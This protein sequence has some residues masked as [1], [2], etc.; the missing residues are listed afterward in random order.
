LE[1]HRSIRFKK[2]ELQGFKS[3]PDKT[4]LLFN[5]DICAIVGP[6]GCGKSNI[7]DALRWVLGEQGPS[8]LRARA[9][10]DVIFNGTAGRKPVG[11][12][13]IT[14]TIECPA[15]SLPLA[16]EEIEISRR[17][18]RSGE[19]EYLINRSP[20]RLKDIVDLFL[21]T[22]MGKG[23][24]SLIE[25]G[26]VDALVTAK[27]ED[28][29]VFLEQMAGIE[30]YKARKKEALSKLTITENN[31]ARVQDVVA[32]VKS[33][34]ISLARQARKASK[35]RSI[36]Q[37]LDELIC[38]S[39]AGRYLRLKN[40]LKSFK[41][42]MTSLQNQMARNSAQHGVQSATLLESRKQV[43]S[44][45]QKL[46]QASEK[47]D[48]AE[49]SINYLKKRIADLKNR[50]SDLQNEH[51]QAIR[52]ISDIENQD[53]DLKTQLEELMKKRTD[54]HDLL[55]ELKIQ[56]TKLE[57]AHQKLTEADKKRS[58]DLAEL[59]NIR[60]TQIEKLSRIQNRLTTITEGTRRVKKQ[61]VIMTSEYEKFKNL[62]TASKVKCSDAATQVKAL[63]KK[64]NQT[65]LKLQKISR[66]IAE[67]KELFN[68]I[69]R[70]NKSIE[71]QLLNVESRLESL[72]DV[73]AVGEDF[74]SG[75][76]SV[77]T[78]FRDMNDSDGNP[79][80]SGTIADLYETDPE[81]EKSVAVA[82]HNYMQD[83]I[84]SSDEGMNKIS[85]FLC[86]QNLGR[87]T[88]R[89]ASR[90]TASASENQIS[91]DISDELIRMRKI[92]KVDQDFSF[93]F[94]RLLTNIYLVTE[95]GKAQQLAAKFPDL[96]IVTKSGKSY[97]P[98]RVIVI[99][100][101][102][103]NR[104]AYRH[105]RIEMKDLEV[106]KNKLQTIL[107]TE[108][109]LQKDADT[110]SKELEKNRITAASELAEANQELAVAN[111]DLDHL[112]K[113]F[114]RITKRLTLAIAEQKNSKEELETLEKQHIMLS[115]QLKTAA[116]ERDLSGEITDSESELEKLRMKSSSVRDQMM[117]S[118]ILLRT[119]EE[120]TRR[121]AREEARVN[122]EIQRLA[123][124]NKRQ[125][126]VVISKLNSLNATQKDRASRE[127]DLQEYLKKEPEN[128]QQID[129]LRRK[130]EQVR[131]ADEA[132]AEEIRDLEKTGR[133]IENSTADVRVKMAGIEA[134]MNSLLEN[135]SLDI[136]SLAEK[137]NSIPD[138]RE[139]KDWKEQIGLLQ[140]SMQVLG[141]VN[142]GAEKEH[143]ELVER[144]RFLEEQTKDLE[145]SIIS[146]RSTIQQINRASRIRFNDA[147]KIVNTYF[148]EVFHQLFEGGEAFLQLLDPD[149]PLESGVDVVCKPP[150]KRARTIDLL[151]GGEKALAALSLLFA[152][153]RYKPSP[154]LFLDE[155]DAPLDEA[156]V[157]RF[158]LFLK[159]LAQVTQV[160]MI[161]HNATTMEA[162]NILYGITMAEP[163]ISK[164][165]SAR[166]SIL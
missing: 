142:L 9:M 154:L 139:L 42:T 97:G 141:D 7:L 136:Q 37:D 146:L 100:G 82:L 119:T 78:K 66:E 69:A 122:L 17:L 121:T 143:R 60:L 112:E 11:M 28:R 102:N 59:R 134:A 152:G 144:N 10:S 70:K 74:D 45:Q 4:E 126:G 81:L 18:Y 158:T 48:Q 128:Q 113:E 36:K 56:T 43:D 44:A 39:Y 156:N 49:M 65:N 161:T 137:M 15:G 79:L 165:V 164:L 163:G 83:V 57:N 72:R 98:G 61:N 2:L 140:N 90:S 58:K 125:N 30:K 80:I 3:F 68:E 38:L 104:L 52:D 157:A 93:M 73:I 16:F 145:D 106:Q 114:S 94:D 85:N 117:E 31:L 62:E 76:R 124:R 87:V 63:Q 54:N 91:Q 50:E 86:E 96:Q 109:A 150:G 130:L 138:E 110:E 55:M 24:F 116:E 8:Q 149:D 115:E 32:E 92:L 40:E 51:D 120:Q 6:N 129:I 25:Q 34:R 35:Y 75:V 155:V 20:C 147:F 127:K 22:G 84:V 107:S 95:D 111:R 71:H 105:R 14:L 103:D 160:V 89:D 47:A 123:E 64:C 53:V 19:S 12:A 162:A 135:N 46:G 77:L 23:A 153:F 99:A 132:L 148:S 29:R 133:E 33:R 118:R 5:E 27:P 131:K 67:K 101:A 88:I 151:S 166:L 1:K 13:V 26:R 21:D 41:N 159:D 108:I